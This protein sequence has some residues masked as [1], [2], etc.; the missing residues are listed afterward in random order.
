MHSIACTGAGECQHARADVD[1]VNRAVHLSSQASKKPAV[2][3]AKHQGSTRVSQIRK[4]R[5]APP[6]QRSAEADIF[7]PPVPARDWIAIHRSI[8][9]SGRNT[10][11]VNRA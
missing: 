5:I 2:A 11:G 1:V 6:F 10:T 4:K 3:I 7:E 8:P 9:A